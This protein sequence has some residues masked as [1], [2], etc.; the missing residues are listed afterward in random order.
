MIT[1]L[2]TLTAGLAIALLAAPAPAAPR[3]TAGSEMILLDHGSARLVFFPRESRL[4][5]TDLGTGVSWESGSS[6]TPWA[7]VTLQQGD[8]TRTVPLVDCRVHTGPEGLQLEYRPDPAHPRSRLQIRITR[9]PDGP[10][11]LFAWQADADLS[12]TRLRLFEGLELGTAGESAA[13]LVPVRTGLR[14]PAEGRQ[15]FRQRFETYAYEGCHMAMLG[16]VRLGAAALWAWD[17]TGVTL[18]LQRRV[19][20]ET[21]HACPAGLLAAFEFQPGSYRIRWLPL[22]R[23]DHVAIARAYRNLAR[24]AGWW[25]PWPEKLRGH[26]ERARYFGAA[27]VKLWS[28]LTR[29]MDETSTREQEVRVNWTF[30]QA[31]RVAEHLKNELKL[32]RILF[33]MGGWIHRGYDNQ[34]PDILPPAPECGGEPAFREVCSRILRLG[35]LLSLHDNYQDMYRDAP[36]WDESWLNKDPDGSP[37]RGGVWAGGRAWIV[38]S[39]K[40]LELAMRPSNLPAVRALSGANAY[41]I[42]TTLAAGLYECHDPQHP[43]TRREDLYWKQALCDYARALFGSFGSEDGREWGIPHADYFEGLAGVAGHPLHNRELL[44]C[45][46][47]EPVP[48]FELAYRECIQVYG[49]YGYDPAQAADYVLHHLLLGRPLHYH[50]LPAGLYWEQD[51]QEHAQPEV[52]Q[53]QPLGPR[54]F[55]IRY[56]W[57]VTAPPDRDWRVFVHFCDARGNILFQ[58]DHDADPPTS[59][60]SPGRHET[61]PFRITVPE[62]LTGPFFIRMGWYDPAS[63]RRALLKGQG[64]AER[65]IRGGRLALTDS[66]VRWEPEPDPPDSTG[67]NPALFLRADRGWAEGF[68]PWDR[69]VKNTYELLSPL[70]ALTATQA[71]TAHAFL[72]TD[73]RVQ[74]TTFGTG[75]QATTVVVNR[76]SQT[77]RWV[78]SRSGSILLPPGGFMVEGDRFIAFHA[79]E[80]NGL[81]YEDAPFFTLQS[82]DGQPLDRSRQ[83]RVYHGFGD[84]RIRLGRHTWEVEREQIVDPGPAKRSV[85]PD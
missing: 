25:V 22:G 66:G 11:L 61:G 52:A 72:T 4:V 43:L 84:P 57:H 23:G 80:W 32:D 21:N 50:N 48:L 68:H 34:H 81:T 63:G 15:P 31:A 56:A 3:Q 42:D 40:A 60:W 58:N 24:A 71:M 18:D 7:S 62:G 44:T 74:M 53:V 78:S 79:R 38:C 76:G 26:P 65:R 77:F 85:Q 45:L 13:A 19:T 16:T 41:F 70:N 49:K 55:T 33:G 5:L 20:G 64:D 69:F 36:S 35:Y 30:D 29:R 37:T 9:P 17:S 83:I 6:E 82:M 27:N 51:P 46:E 28:L 14:V 10:G 59:R 75:R 8:G 39:R 1:R 54:T 12:V 73:H 2:R 67:L 47:A